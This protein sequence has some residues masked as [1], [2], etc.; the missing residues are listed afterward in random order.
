MFTAP[1]RSLEY[2][3]NMLVRNFAAVALTFIAFAPGYARAQQPST[4]AASQLPN[5]PLAVNHPEDLPLESQ[6]H[7]T[8]TVAGSPKHTLTDLTHIAIS[9]V[10]LRP[11]DLKWILPLTGATAAAFATDTHTMRDVVSRDPSF[12]DISGNV[13][14]GLRDSMIALPVALFGLGH[15]RRNEHARETGI[16]AGEAMVDAIVVDEISK[17]TTYRERPYVDNG[18]GDFYIGK[19]G[20]VNSS[21]VSGHSM[22]AWSSAAVMAGESHRKLYDLL[23]Y[24]AA[25]GVS[26]SRVTAQQHFPTDVLLGSAGGWLI[27]HFVYRAHHHADV[28]PTT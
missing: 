6:P 25:A 13:S 18:Q 20:G 28:R 21:F 16:L 10:Y 1:R 2:R 11:R 14:D 23:L 7:S 24:T 19:S 4:A 9:P 17:L 26:V 5:A 8:V 3:E 15:L 27:G 22:I 12:N